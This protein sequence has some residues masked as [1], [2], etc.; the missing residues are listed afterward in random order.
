VDFDKLRHI[1]NQLR[2]DVPETRARYDA[3]ECSAD[4]LA[5]ALKRFSDHITGPIPADSDSIE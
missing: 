4:K 3:Q 2:D 1:E 5:E